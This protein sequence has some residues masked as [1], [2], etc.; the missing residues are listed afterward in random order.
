MSVENMGNG[1]VKVGVKQEDLEASIAGLRQLKPIL[2]AQVT[3]GNGN[4]TRQAAIDR[5]EI[6][7]HFD[8][9]INAMLIL[10]S[11]FEA[12]EMTEEE[13]TK[14]FEAMEREAKKEIDTGFST[15]NLAMG[16]QELYRWLTKPRLCA[17]Y[18]ERRREWR[19]KTRN[20]HDLL[21]I[22]QKRQ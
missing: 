14:W 8:T 16:S 7:K 19:V 11:A 12:S 17:A 10:Y 3:R 20:T 5:A 9:A 2:Q 4:N 6:G 15:W 18:Q 13:I 22:R 21:Q 1:Y